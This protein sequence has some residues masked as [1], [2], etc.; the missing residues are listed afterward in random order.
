MLVAQPFWRHQ[1]IR[2]PSWKSKPGPP[3]VILPSEAWQSET[4]MHFYCHADRL[5]RDAGS[6]PAFALCSSRNIP[7]FPVLDGSGGWGHWG[8]PRFY[9]NVREWLSRNKS[10]WKYQVQSVCV[11]KRHTAF[12]CG[13]T[14]QRWTRSDYR[15]DNDRTTCD[16]MAQWCPMK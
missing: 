9:K 10:V 13:K 11:L 15:A 8:W 5:R 4:H 12:M 7:A 1:R 2:L 3:V 16:K 14:V 6:L